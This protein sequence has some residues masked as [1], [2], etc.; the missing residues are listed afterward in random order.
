MIDYR[1]SDLTA[2]FE[3]YENTYMYSSLMFCDDGALYVSAFNGDTNELYRMTYNEEAGIYNAVR[4]ADVGQDVWPAI[5][6]RVTSNNPANKTDST[7]AAFP[8]DA[9]RLEAKTMSMEELAYRTT[10]ANTEIETGE[11]TVTLTIDADVATTNGLTTVSY[12][13][14]KLALDSFVVN[15]D[16][17]ARME[18]SGKITFGYVSLAGIPAD[19]TVATLTFRVLETVDT[20]I[21][22]EH[23]QV[24]NEPG[25]AEILF[26]TFEHPNTE[27]RNAAE[28]T[29]TEDGYTGDTYCLD[30]GK[31]VAEGEVIPAT[32]HTGELVGVIPATCTKDGYTGDLVCSVCGELLEKG[33][34]IPAHCAS[35][36]YS[37]LNVNA[38]Y[39]EYTDYVI[40]NGLMNGVGG[41]KFNP[42]GTVDRA[43]MVTV[44]YR[45]AGEPEVTGETKFA[46]VKADQW[47]TD[48]VIW[49]E[50]T[51]IAKGMTEDT[52]AP[53]ATVTREQAATFLYRYVTE[54][55]GVEA[56]EG[57]DLSQ[58]KDASAIS[59][60]AKEAMAWAV[61]EELFEGFTDGTI[62]ARETLTRVQLA[63]LLTVLDQAF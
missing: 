6:T 55:L 15:G 39:H 41:G 31:L 23:Q 57:A 8:A 7:D 54:Y 26:V 51:G 42:N 50:E 62:Q 48:A 38:W 30:C 22:V 60:Y 2:A 24:N 33:E 34:V 58:F 3:G 28:A 45:M 61:A 49:A 14:N 27:I 40:A 37:D 12:D 20:D 43:M 9:R 36:D 1:E 47:Y 29:C 19:G 5:I 25:T 21:I 59:G 4:I 63:K 53:G 44:L 32:G 56:I 17:T 13:A 52:F 10:S 35:Q 11:E 18:E 16:Y 46:D